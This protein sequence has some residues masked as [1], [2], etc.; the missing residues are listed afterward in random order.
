ML[1]AL[2]TRCSTLVD[3]DGKR[4]MAGKRQ[5]E[6]RRL[7]RDGE[8]RVARRVVVHFDEINAALLE[9]PYSFTSVLS[10]GDSA[11]E[12]PVR[13]RTVQYRTRCDYFGSAE[14]VAAYTIAQWQ[15]EVRV[16]THVARADHSIRQIELQ[17]LRA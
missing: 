8:E 12:R 4:N 11:S 10:V 16:R 9:I 3:G 15:N 5:P 2:D 1:Y 14:L 7:V 17:R 13:R 6:F